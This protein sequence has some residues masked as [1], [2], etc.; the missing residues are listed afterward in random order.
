AVGEIDVVLRL[1]LVGHGRRRHG[2]RLD[3]DRL[4][5]DLDGPGAAAGALELVDEGGVDATRVLGLEALVD[6]LEVLRA[7]RDASHESG[8]HVKHVL[9]A[10]RLRAYPV[11]K[12]ESAASRR[13][14]TPAK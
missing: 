3:G 11:V 4:V 5:L 6:G 2:A 1:H 13:R 10:S 9:V 12:I 8:P 14:S 7:A